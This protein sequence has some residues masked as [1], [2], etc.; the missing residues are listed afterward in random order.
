MLTINRAGSVSNT[1][2]T[3][4]K[5]RYL[6]PARKYRQYR[7]LVSV[8]CPSLHE[9]RNSKE[10]LNNLWDFSLEMMRNYLHFL[11][12]IS[13]YKFSG[14]FAL[15]AKSHQKN[16]QEEDQL[17]QTGFEC[18]NDIQNPLPLIFDKDGNLVRLQN[19]EQRSKSKSNLILLAWKE[20]LLIEM[21]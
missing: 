18:K 14:H 1:N 9:T 5:Y 12:S 15:I 20:C 3:W 16:C 17:V 11:A 21:E 7:Y 4:M 13:I 2:D 10:L 8:L 6:P 19:K